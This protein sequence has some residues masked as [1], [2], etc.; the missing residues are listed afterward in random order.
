MRDL[1]EWVCPKL[2]TI[3]DLVGN[4]LGPWAISSL[5]AL[6]NLLDKAMN[7][8]EYNASCFVKRKRDTSP[9]RDRPSPPRAYRKKIE[10]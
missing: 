2:D 6:S 1:S 3:S 4:V 10:K 5:E 7:I 8:S 9:H